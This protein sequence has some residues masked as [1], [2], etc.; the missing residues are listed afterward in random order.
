MRIA[1][2]GATGF[3]GGL[4]VAE[5]GRRGLTP[6]LVGRDGTRLRAAAANAGVPDAEIRIAG[7]D[8]IDSLTAAFADCDA[9]VNAAGPFTRWGAPVIEA[10]IAARTHYV[11]TTGEPHYIRT[12][13]HTYGSA[14]AQAGVSIVPAMADDGGPGDL[15]ASL[16]AARLG[17]PVDE[18]LIADLRRPGAVSR[19]TARTMAAALT[20]NAL[21]FTDGTWHPVGESTTPPLHLPDE[22]D[23]VPVAV[24]ALPGVVT[25]PQ[26]VRARRVH[27]VIRADV[28]AL[29]GALTP[30][31][32]DSVPS[33]IDE[34]TRRA[35]RWF[36]LAEATGIDGTRTRGWVTG[37]DG[38]GLTA[39]IAVEGARRLA[40]EGARAGVL[41]P[42]QA[43]DPAGFL[44]FL[45]T[46][47]VTW[48]VEQADI[49]ARR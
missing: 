3:T 1:V 24:L 39:V 19:G 7:L 29:F 12:V 16:T 15:I 27:S 21:E 46:F 31:V 49:T 36:M 25:I 8:D 34:Q 40:A 38:Y 22:P 35:G 23:P 2:Y 18:M 30:E 45:T 28:A 32:V 6:V 9:V 26:H 5:V 13:F 42:A 11:D 41:T 33:T 47:E 14:A 44:D 4:A 10:A 20:L 48:Q 37:I 43:F 17:S